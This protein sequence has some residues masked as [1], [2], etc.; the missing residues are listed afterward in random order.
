MTELKNIL[1][2]VLGILFFLLVGH[3]LN[4]QSLQ[5]LQLSDIFRI[6][7]S[8]DYISDMTGVSGVAF[9]DLNVDGRPDL[10]L[11]RFEGN[12]H[13]LVNSGA[14]RPFKDV[15]QI[16]RLSGNLRPEGVYH[17]ES[18]STV[19]DR[20]NGTIIV[21][22]DNDDDGD[23]IMT[24]WGISTSVYKN[25]GQFQFQN[26]TEYVE[27]F[28]PIQANGCFSADIDN[29][30]FPDLF[31]TD[32][33]SSNRL[34]RNMGDGN[35][36]DIT[37]T[38]GLQ[39]TGP[40][41]GAAFSDIDR[42]G[43][44]DLYV[45]RYNLPDLFYV[46][47]GNGQFKM[48]N[49]PLST[50]V[51]SLK[52]TS[53]TFADTDNDADFDMVITVYGSRTHLYENQTDPDDSVWVFKDTGFDTL[54]HDDNLSLGSV[55]ADFNNDGYQDIFITRTGA[56]SL[57]LNKK[58]GS[59][60]RIDE[61]GSAEKS[62]ISDQSK[63]AA[64]ADFDFDGALDLFIANKNTPC[65]FYRNVL[66]NDNYIKIFLKGIRSNRDAIGARVEIY[67]TGFL[68]ENEQLLGSREITA[69]S[70]YYSLNEPLVH[71]GTDTLGSVDA[72]VYF[73]SGKILEEKNLK[74]GATYTL[75]EYP[76]VTSAIIE[77][78]QHI[79]YLMGQSSFWYQVLLTLLF[80]A[81]IVLFVRLGSRRYKWS[82]GTA[83][84]YLIGFFL[85]ALIS[86]A[87]L[88]KLGLVYILSI[89]DLLTLVFVAI[90]F[91]N[92]ERLYRLRIIRE[93]Y[94]MVLI[95]LSNQIVNIH[96]DQELY[97][98]VVNNISQITEFDKV[99]ILPLNQKNDK[100]DQ[101]VSRG[102]SLSSNAL[103]EFPNQSGLRDLLLQKKHLQYSDEKEFQPIFEALSSI[104][105]ISIGRN[106]NLFGILSIGTDQDISPLTGDDIELF[107]SL[108][109]QMAIAIENNEYIRRSTEM[110]K[111]LT[112]AEVREK[113]LKELEAT[114]A[115]L[116]S[117]NQDLQKL[118]DE[119]KNTQAQL[120]HSEKMA[121]L[122]QL[123]AGI[124][125][126]LNNPIG[127]I[128]ANV[129]QL[130]SYTDKIE[131]FT[132]QIESKR[133][134]SGQ[135]QTIKI[136]SILPDLK[137]LIEDTIH[138]SQMVKNL[139]DNL[140]KFSHL[141]QAQWKE[142]DIH[143]GIESSLMIL[144]PELKHRIKVNKEFKADRLIECNPGQINQVF[145]N[146]LS[147]AAQAIEGEGT[148]KVETSQ[149]SENLFVII[150]DTGSGIPSDIVNKIFD[151]FFTT[152]DVGKGTGLGLS[153][154]YSII[155]NHNGQIN[156]E[157]EVGKG[158]TFTLTLPFNV[159]DKR[160]NQKN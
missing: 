26:I 74:T 14:Y 51:D 73:P 16:A 82:A 13:F 143:Q 152:K 86:I 125:H 68:G 107:E 146:L 76:V 101:S 70:G 85:L 117:K 128:Y 149:D 11:T 95:N 135:P 88:K 40:S 4:A 113:Y 24:G 145:L 129:K 48:M 63:G 43:D 81:L 69:G 39:S 121:S 124:S 112:E 133:P 123:V 58:D 100:F 8:S 65:Q 122:G 137:N 92:S 19:L 148:I 61:I 25:N 9:R 144:N 66:E 30:R 17:F 36:I 67:K 1:N 150:S 38:A 119:L 156:V 71:F 154:S 32:E 28:P 78:G 126:E 118:Y 18:G 140:R 110:I 130:K 120:I 102:L 6:N 83:S 93:R 20:K 91:I 77:S 52:S 47:Q 31:I 147:N 109:N 97:Q 72:I 157:S 15:T 142:V 155:K 106:E 46:N 22:I 27:I 116:D 158:T 21:D 64:F 23:V 80:F 99:A 153:I 96:D 2:L 114:N 75:V 127:F 105:F 42:D 151:P 89:I 41:R 54:S 138:G 56:N 33:I 131:K 59:F 5:Q 34:L 12:N 141:D 35:F 139:V 108:G 104:I 49:L 87:A 45:C 53:V 62:D 111:K 55:I 160:Q 37:S 90:F 134:E 79:N 50:L 103:N 44:Q 84:G 57:Y 7:Q 10:Y 60:I 94:R 98:T 136:E 29:D 132:N 115:V 159:G 3:D